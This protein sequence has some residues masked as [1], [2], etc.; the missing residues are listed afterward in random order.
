MYSSKKPYDSPPSEYS[1][2]GEDYACDAHSAVPGSYYIEDAPQYFYKWSSPPRVVQILEAIGVLLCLTIFACVA[3]TLAWEY[4]YGYGGLYGSGMGGYYGG[5]LSGGMGYYGGGL[6]AGYGGYYGGYYGVTN[7]RS[8]GGFMIAMAVL[9]LVALLALAVTSLTKSSGSRSRRFYLVAIIVC[10]ILAFLMLIASIVYIMGVNPRAQMSSSYYYSA[11]PLLAMCNQIYSS[12]T[13]FNQYLYHYC[14]VDPQEAIAIVCGFLLVILLCLICFF[15][16]KTRQKIWRFGKH[17]IYW[18]QP[19]AFQ[20]GPNVEE[21]VKN[22]AD[23]ASTHDETA[24]L[25]YSEKPTSPIN[26][27]A[28]PYN[29]RTSQNGYYDVEEPLRYSSTLEQKARETPSKPSARRGRRRRRNPELEESQYETDYTTAMESSDEKDQDDWSSLYPPLTSDG[30]RQKYKQ[31]FDADLRHYKQLCAE[32]DGINDQINQLSKQLDHL[33]E[34]SLQYQG[35]AKEYNRLKDLKRT[36]DYQSKKM[37]SKSL[38]NK[39]FHIKRM[40]SEYDKH[41]G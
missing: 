40:V 2:P 29:Y 22:V 36:P 5:G 23:R 9:C 21:W 24:T 7:P 38:R 28:S 6:G 30:D 3:S 32:M 25:A 17:N 14:M 20:E 33:V 13:Y 39:L 1:P 41:R 11:S 27:P 35:V 37:E 31:E 18:N 10:A 15:A 19:P 26:A 8:A 34:G 16:H 12:G 4:G